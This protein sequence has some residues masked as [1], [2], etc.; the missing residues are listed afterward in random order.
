MKTVEQI[1]VENGFYLWERE[2]KP[3]IL[4]ANPDDELA[5]GYFCVEKAIEATCKAYLSEWLKEQVIAAIAYQHMDSLQPALRFATNVKFRSTVAE[6]KSVKL[7]AL[8]EEE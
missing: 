5:S 4:I 1:A 3:S 2:G 7:I 6:N 8:P